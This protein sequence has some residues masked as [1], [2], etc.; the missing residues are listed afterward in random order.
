M[1]PPTVHLVGAGPGDP[2][3]LTLKAAR[4]LQLADVV[5]HDRL[6]GDGV[7]SLVQPRAR[8]IDVGKAPGRHAMRQDEINE[9]LRRLA[10]P[11]RV[12]VRLKG[13]DPFVFGRGGEEAL[14]LLR[15]GIAVEVVPGITAAAGCAAS[16]LIPLTH[17]GLATGVRFVTGHCR[18]AEPLELDWRGLADP[19]TTL[20]V[21]MGLA[22]ID[23]IVAQLVAAGLPPATPAAAIAEGTTPRERVV[24]APLAT[25]AEAVRA[26]RLGSPT[27]FVIGRVVEALALPVEVAVRPAPLAGLEVRGHG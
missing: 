26:A 4:L 25:I 15:H 8:R 12:V 7:L 13:G 6:V 24:R 19:D 20:V 23:R 22:H 11:D 18:E 1:Q 9:L 27:L 16:A 21:Y 17:R 14:H 5:V 3:L 2:E 10:A